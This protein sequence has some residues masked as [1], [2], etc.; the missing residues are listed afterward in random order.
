VWGES[1]STYENQAP[2]AGLFLDRDGVIVEEI[3]YLGRAQ[4]VRLLPGAASLIALANDSGVPIVVVTNQ[5]GIGRGYFGWNGFYESLDQM[6]RLLRSEGGD[7]DAAYACPFHRD[8]NAPYDVAD[9]PARK[10][11]A[12]MV[13]R[14]ARDLHLDLARSWI[15]GDT[16]SDVLTAKSAGLA[17]AVHVLTGHGARDRDAVMKLDRGNLRIRFATKLGEVMDLVG[18]LADGGGRTQTSHGHGT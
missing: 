9:H 13:V 1:Y 8:A 5:A 4:D 12:G 18:Q 11:N 7:I 2:R 6:R 10:P 3:E 16:V 17:G 14:A 15:V